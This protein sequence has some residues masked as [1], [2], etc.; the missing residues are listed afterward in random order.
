M[1]MG[2]IRRLS[3]LL[4]AM[5]LLCTCA[6]GDTAG[7]IARDILV[8][9]GIPKAFPAGTARLSLPDMASDTPNTLPVRI[10]GVDAPG[11]GTALDT[12]A[13]VSA[14]ID[15]KPASWQVPV[16]WLDKTFRVVESLG[17][18]K[19]CLPVVAFALPEGCTFDGVIDLDADLAGILAESGRVLTLSQPATGTIYILGDPFTR[20]NIVPDNEAA[21]TD[22]A[23]CV[24]PVPR[25][26]GTAVPS[27]STPAARPVPTGEPVDARTPLEVF[28]DKYWGRFNRVDC[29]VR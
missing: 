25:E 4:M 2:W 7:K 17:M 15:G 24:P 6:V 13:E 18:D 21:D 3:A 11:I 10:S 12:A 29:M 5:T 16:V 1:Y 20:W 22:E 19:S 27:I 28:A 23:P 8:S 9:E 26:T 14:R